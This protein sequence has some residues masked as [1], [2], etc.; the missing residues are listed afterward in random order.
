M[1][2]NNKVNDESTSKQ[3]KGKVEDEL[4]LLQHARLEN[5]KSYDEYGD[6]NDLDLALALEMSLLT[7]SL[8]LPSSQ[9]QSISNTSNVLSD[10]EKKKESESMAKKTERST[11]LSNNPPPG[12]STL[13]N[14][15]ANASSHG[16]LNVK[17]SNERTLDKDTSENNTNIEFNRQSWTDSVMSSLFGTSKNDK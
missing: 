1:P 11:T 5:S 13:S 7:N 15:N 14:L 12:F 3:S 8:F 10:K 17:K 16:F 2:V 9:V 6:D 4:F